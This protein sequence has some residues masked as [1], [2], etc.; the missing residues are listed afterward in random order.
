MCLFTWPLL[1]QWVRPAVWP[2]CLPALHDHPRNRDAAGYPTG[3]LRAH[4][5]DPATT[6]YL[7]L[8]EDILAWRVMPSA[9]RAYNV[10]QVALVALSQVLP[11]AVRGTC[12]AV[13]AA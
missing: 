3:Q 5:R 9:Q 2:L 1:R 11:L 12:D 13:A 4:V 6:S 8:G 10:V 7:A